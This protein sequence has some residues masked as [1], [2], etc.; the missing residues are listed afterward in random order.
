MSWF[1][2]FGLI[3]VVVILIPN[4]IFGIT[5]PKDFENKYNNKAVETLEQIGRF[6]CFGFMFISPPFVCF[7]YWFGSAQIVY[8]IFGAVLVALYCLGW[9]I[10]WRESSVRRALALSI[11]PSLLFLESGILTMHI[12]LIILSVI[13]AFCHI[14]ISY[15]NAVL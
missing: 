9:A 6:G 4:I 1:N 5:H 14:T 15:K 2:L 12:P 11:L 13:F 7:G 8:I 3:F 10:F